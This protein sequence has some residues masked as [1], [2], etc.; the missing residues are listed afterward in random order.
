VIFTDIWYILGAFGIF[1]GPLVYFGGLWYILGAFGN[2]QV[3]WYI[4]PSFGI[5]LPR[6]IWQP[7]SQPVMVAREGYPIE[8]HTVTTEDCYILQMHRIPYGKNSPQVGP[9]FLNLTGTCKLCK[10]C[11]G[12]FFFFF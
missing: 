3:F 5:F 10:A 11:P 9:S 7:I 8:T 1:W 12:G 6:K 4:L 2:F